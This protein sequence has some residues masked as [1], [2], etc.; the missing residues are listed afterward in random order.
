[1]ER[2]GYKITHHKNPWRSY[3]NTLREKMNESNCHGRYDEEI[4]R[5][6]ETRLAYRWGKGWIS[7]YD[8]LFLKRGDLSKYSS[9][10]LM[11]EKWIKLDERF[12]NEFKIYGF[13]INLRW[14][15]SQEIREV[16]DRAKKELE[17]VFGRRVPRRCSDLIFRYQPRDFFRNYFEEVFKITDASVANEE[18]QL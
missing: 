2:L 7:L 5:M 8:F 11:R 14:Q 12:E 10:W 4:V 9:N 1:M 16:G 3:Y 6:K 13:A 17:R 15:R 18:S